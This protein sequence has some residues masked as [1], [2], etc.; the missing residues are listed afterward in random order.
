MANPKYKFF[1]EELTADELPRYSNGQVQALHFDTPEIEACVKRIQ[2][3]LEKRGYKLI[4]HNGGNGFEYAK[5]SDC[6]SAYLGTFLNP[7]SEDDEVKLYSDKF[8][9]SSKYICVQEVSRHNGTAKNASLKIG[10]RS[11]NPVEK[12]DYEEEEFISYRKDLTKHKITCLTCRIKTSGKNPIPYQTLRKIKP[13]V[14]EKVLNKIL[15]E[16]EKILSTAE[17]QD[18]SFL[19]QDATKFPKSTEIEWTKWKRNDNK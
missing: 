9:I 7:F 8:A 1:Q 12:V 17:S 6:K 3:E 11:S 15:D 18:L 4:R 5:P 10:V 2:S 13:T 14:S 16:A 19:E